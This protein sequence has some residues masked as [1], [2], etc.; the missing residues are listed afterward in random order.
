MHYSKYSRA[1]TYIYDNNYLNL[2]IFYKIKMKNYLSW[3]TMKMNCLHE[4]MHFFFASEHFES[5]FFAVI[6]LFIVPFLYP[7]L[8]IFADLFLFLSTFILFFLFIFPFL[9]NCFSPF[10]L[11]FPFFYLFLLAFREVF[12]NFFRV[13]YQ[14]FSHFCDF[15]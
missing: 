13:S 3:K 4:K 10:I 6:Y 11:I 2:A 14:V 8:S 5:F 12:C 9:F 7:F 1:N 15:I